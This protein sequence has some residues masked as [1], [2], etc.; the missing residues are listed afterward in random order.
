[1]HAIM[2]CLTVAVNNRK[3]KLPKIDAMGAF[4]Q[5]E[6]R[7]PPVY[8]C[9]HKRLTELITEILPGICSYVCKDGML[10]CHLMKTL[11][12]CVQAS[13]LWYKKLRILG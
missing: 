13:K 3:V 4:N 5:T 11:Y 10:Y 2:A 9:C 6:M 12:G 8:I 7:G 1:M